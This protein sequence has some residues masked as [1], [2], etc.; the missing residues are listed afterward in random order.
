M[1][2][3]AQNLSEVLAELADQSGQIVDESVIAD[4]CKMSRISSGQRKFAELLTQGI[5]QGHAYE[6]A[7]PDIPRGPGLRARA[8]KL[9]K[10]NKIKQLLNLLHGRA[11][12]QTPNG[13][14]SEVMKILWSQAR[15]A[16]P[17]VSHRAA[18]KLDQIHDR[19]RELKLREAKALENRHPTEILDEI[20]QLGAHGVLIAMSLAQAHGLPYRPPDGA[21]LPSLEA[22]TALLRR[23]AE[24]AGRLDAIKK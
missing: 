19:D 16:D 10:T 5:G 13:D 9:A 17:N 15:S 4:F 3:E 1:A 11:P 18:A 24:E 23:P 7:F 22:V 21:P 14:Q 6:M 12:N 20:A 2:K 8:S